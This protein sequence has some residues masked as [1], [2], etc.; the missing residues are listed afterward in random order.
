[1]TPAEA[2]ARMR[3]TRA[4][5]KTEKVLPVWV[6]IAILAMVFIPLVWMML[7]GDSWRPLHN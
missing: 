7:T 1:M 6:T 2:A 3:A 4:I 5:D